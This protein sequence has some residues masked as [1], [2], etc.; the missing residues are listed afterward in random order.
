MSCCCSCPSKHVTCSEIQISFNNCGLTDAELVHM[1]NK[2][3]WSKMSTWR[4]KVKKLNLL[5]NVL[6]HTG[7]NKILGSMPI[8]HLT[9]LDLSYNFM[10]VEGLQVLEDVMHKD[11][12]ES[13]QNL[14][15]QNCLTCDP[16]IYLMVPF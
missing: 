1:T 12:L 6:T 13:I 8:D 14:I 7:K 2:L 16:D 11:M 9:H 3:D 4:Q 10:G 5:G 15:L